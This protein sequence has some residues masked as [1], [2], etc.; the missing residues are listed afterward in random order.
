MIKLTMKS[1]FLL[2]LALSIA[3]AFPAVD[4]EKPKPTVLR[5]DFVNN[6]DKGYNFQ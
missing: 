6:G 3:V 2:A 4:D 5:S 1:I